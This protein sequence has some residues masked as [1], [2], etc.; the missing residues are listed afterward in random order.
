MLGTQTCDKS[1]GEGRVRLPI[2]AHAQVAVTFSADGYLP[3]VLPFS[4]AGTSPTIPFTLG[5]LESIR[6]RYAA[7]G[8][9]V[10]DPATGVVQVRATV[11]GAND[12]RMEGV[13]MSLG[14]GGAAA[15]YRGADGAFAKD[16]QATSTWGA[17]AFAGLQPGTV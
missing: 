2:P 8:V 1:D 10:P 4:T 16:L 12:K 17:A 13:S 7:A 5:S 6:A 11:V 14:A 3:A 15:L 9:T